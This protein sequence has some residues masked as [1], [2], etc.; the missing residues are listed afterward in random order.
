MELVSIGVNQGYEKVRTQIGKELALLKEQGF[1]IEVKTNNLGKLTFLKY[2]LSNEKDKNYD[3]LRTIFIRYIANT[4]T[5]VILDVYQEKMVTKFIHDNYYYF[6]KKE[7]ESIKNKAL[8]FL[9]YT[10]VNNEDHVILNTS[11]KSKILKSIIEY[12]EEN[13]EIVIEGFIN[14]RLRFIIDSIEEAVDRAVEEVVI[15]KEYNEFIKILQYFIDIQ[16]PK[17]D[18]VNVVFKK[19]NTYLLLDENY[20]IVKNEILEEI[21]IELL[22]SNINYDDML[23]S[24]LITLAPRKIVIHKNKDETNTEIV[25]II[26]NVFANKVSVCEG[27]R[28]CNEFENKKKE[29]NNDKK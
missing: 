2:Q 18:I 9:N 5:N 25:K 21:A 11:R 19:D 29:L 7:K 1:H 20:N 22:E 3:N 28:L 16:E 26:K 8:E 17:L 6:D 13:N 12:L 4:I 10:E 14:F 27:C 15:E 23:I 24:S